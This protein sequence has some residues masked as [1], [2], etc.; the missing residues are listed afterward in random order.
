MS[1]QTIPLRFRRAST[2]TF[3]WNNLVMLAAALLDP[4]ALVLSLWIAAFY[5]HGE[6]TPPYLILSLLVFSLTL[7]GTIRIQAPNLHVIRSILIEWSLIAALFYFFGNATGY[8]GY[9][10]NRAMMIWLW[11]APVSQ[12]GV[13]IALRNF[14]PSL[15]HIQGEARRAVIAG[16]NENGITLARQMENSPFSAIRLHGFF[17]DRL[18]ERVGRLTDYP[19]LGTINELPAYVQ[20]NRIEA[21]YISLPMATQPRILKLLDGLSNTTASI[22]FVPDMFI[23]DLMQGRIDSVGDMPVISVCETPFTGVN[24][25]LKR[26]SD[27]V[28]SLLILTLISPLLLMIA[29]AV[30]LTSPGPVIFK[31]RRYGLNGE[32]IL[33][34][35]FR[36]MTVCEDGETVQ[37]AQRNDSRVTPIGSFLR[38]TS[39]D[40]LPQFFNVLQGSMSIVGPRPHAVAHNELYRKLIKGYMVRHKV[41]PGITGW[42]QV[43]GWRGE[44]DTLEKMKSRI[45]YDLAYLRNWSLRLDLYIIYKTVMVVLKDKHAY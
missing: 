22:Y 43:N 23:T 11:L 12:F 8:L 40:E 37:Q 15:A 31:Q 9:F 34:Y 45:D 29:A 30:K 33:V 21:I 1:N 5:V 44:T 4:V 27:I 36:S 19:L 24:G 41:K 26:L 16:V 14:A 18:R 32:E 10:D 42:A 20:R 6:V 3:G 35:K 13:N 28:L 7:P 38:K 25:M 39:L 2:P 17:D